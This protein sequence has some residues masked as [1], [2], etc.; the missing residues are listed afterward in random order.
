MAG[1]YQFEETDKLQT[2]KLTNGIS[3]RLAQ[4]VRVLA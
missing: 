3:G 4:L 2:Y 1:V